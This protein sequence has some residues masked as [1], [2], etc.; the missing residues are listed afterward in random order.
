MKYLPPLLSYLWPLAYRGANVWTVDHPT[1]K[2]SAAMK[3]VFKYDLLVWHFFYQR[4]EMNTENKTTIVYPRVLIVAPDWS[5][6]ETI[7][8]RLTSSF[9]EPLCLY[10]GK[11]AESEFY[12][13][14]FAS[15]CDLLIVTPRILEELIDKRWIHFE[16]VHLLIVSPSN[17]YPSII[18]SI[19][20]RSIR[21]VDGS[22]RLIAE[23]NAA[24][25][26][27]K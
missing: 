22:T 10:E 2:D 13:P 23:T 18:R 21:R 4:T 26:F 8:E 17:T 16:R 25:A 20:V 12:K 14:L 1:G 15:A 3:F 9:I 5:S 24:F 6:C 27:A 11:E 19:S 7:K